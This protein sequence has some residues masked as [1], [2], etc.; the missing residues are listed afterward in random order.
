MKQRVRKK[1]VQRRQAIQYSTSG[2]AA[3]TKRYTPDEILARAAV[4]YSEHRELFK[5][6][7]DA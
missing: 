6:L 4:I 3:I 1:L 7:E 5:R 2:P